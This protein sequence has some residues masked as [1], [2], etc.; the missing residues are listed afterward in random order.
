VI[1]AGQPLF[2]ADALLRHVAA[3][4]PL[5]GK[6][7]L[8]VGGYVMPRSLER[9]IRSVLAPHLAGV[10]IVQFFGAAEV[11]AGCLIA[12]DRDGA[13]QLIYYP[14][15]D[16]EP[17]VDGDALLLTLR[18]PD[19]TP[20]ALRHRTGDRARREGDG[21]VIDNPDRLHPGVERALE[22]WSELDWGRRTGYLRRDGET[23][24]IQLREGE[25]PRQDD[26]IDHFDFARRH[27]FSWLDK[28]TWR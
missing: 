25:A 27:G 9:M 24:H 1:L 3:G 18:A 6:M 20:I 4:R 19:G 15:A 14:R 28:P 2:L 17:E 22:S 26:E 12:R 21:W 16:V 23:I 7:M 8:W 11:D 10:S 5:P 13:G